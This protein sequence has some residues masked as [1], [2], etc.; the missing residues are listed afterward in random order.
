MPLPTRPSPDKPLDRA[1]LLALLHAALIVSEN[2]YARL[3]ALGW[4]GAFPGDLEMR[5]LYARSLVQ[6]GLLQQALPVLEELVAA[7][8]EFAAAQELLASTLYLV[9]SIQSQ[10]VEGRVVAL[11][12]NTAQSKNLPGWAKILRGTRKIL[13]PDDRT[14]Y[15]PKS[16]LPQ[17]LLDQALSVLAENPTGP[18]AAVTHLRLSLADP[19]LEPATL[20]SLAQ[21]YHQRW[22]DCLPCKLIYADIL[23]DDG[24]HDQGLDLLHQAMSQDITGQVPERLWGPQHP[25]KPLWPSML[26]IEPGSPSAPQSIPVPAEITARF[27]WNQLPAPAVPLPTPP[28][29]M[30]SPSMAAAHAAP[31]NLRPARRPI[32]HYVPPESLQRTLPQLDAI[33][34]RIKK[35]GLSNLDGRYPVYVILSARSALERQ[36]TQKGFALIDLEL[37][38]LQEALA[39]TGRWDSLLFYVDDP[40]MAPARP[41]FQLKPAIP[42]DPWEVKLALADLDVALGAQGEMIGAVLVVGGPQVIPFHQLPNPVDD[43][44]PL[45]AS[46]NPYS[47]RDENYF[48]PEWPVGR[49]PGDASSNPAALLQTIR[50][51][52]QRHRS[53]PLTQSWPAEMWRRLTQAVRQV[54]ARTPAQAHA[55]GY[56][57][58]VWRRASLSVYR[59]IGKPSAMLVSPPVQI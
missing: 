13:S 31:A 3:T 12:G 28:V 57:A 49:L 8:P 2:R 54:L 17:G 15:R 51:I 42:T 45:V 52:A 9:G 14:A 27:G 19:T 1:S 47:T 5:L 37:R 11:G 40:D 16:P 30:P 26:A 20:H 41:A 59:T 25:Y 22:P 39:R 24:Q 7:D 29:P 34:R 55:M 50:Q 48:I 4:L 56:S 32:P 18:L 46:D 35:P 23:M 58:A 6:E 33:A 53:N 36:Y 43:D 44:D 10:E 38:A 21:A